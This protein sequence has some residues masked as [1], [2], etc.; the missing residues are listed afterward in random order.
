MNIYIWEVFDVQLCFVEF[1]GICVV[2][3]SLIEFISSAPG[4]PESSLS[5]ENYHS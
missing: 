4:G 3:L 1:V 2:L 5:S